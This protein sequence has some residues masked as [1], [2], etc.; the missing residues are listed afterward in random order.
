MSDQWLFS[1]L[2]TIIVKAIRSTIDRLQSNAGS[3]NR[4][5][6]KFAFY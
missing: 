5:K 4:K 3:S 1:G 6:R 2:I